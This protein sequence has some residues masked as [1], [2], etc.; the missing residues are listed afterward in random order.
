VDIEVGQSKEGVVISQRKYT[1]DILKET[2]MIYCKLG[3]CPMDPNQNLM[4][5]REKFSLIQINIED[6]LENLYIS[7]L[8]D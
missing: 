2:S 1:L 8:L 6:R 3:D 5:S 7:L 4:Q